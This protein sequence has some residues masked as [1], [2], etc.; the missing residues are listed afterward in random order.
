MQTTG[1][2]GTFL[3]V[4]N[5]WSRARFA[6]WHK[7]IQLLMGC[8]EN[9]GRRQPEFRKLLSSNHALQRTAASLPSGRAV[10]GATKNRLR[11]NDRPI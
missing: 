8:E 4:V 5:G 11:L 2:K 3:V 7:A 9:G 1:T 6:T 10:L